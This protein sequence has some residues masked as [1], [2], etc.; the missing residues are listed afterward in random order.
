ML[1]VE[2]EKGVQ[3]LSVK[4]VV[5]A[6]LI[7]L[8]LAIWQTT[9]MSWYAPEGHGPNLVLVVVAY[10]GLFAPF[11]AGAVT[12]T[13]L[14]FIYDAA[15]GGILGLNAGVYLA[16]FLAAGLIRQKLDPTAPF[17]LVIFILAIAMGAGLLNFLALFI[18][19]WTIPLTPFTL[20][21]TL[22]VFWV[23]SA[24]TAV[25]GPFLFWFMTWVLPTSGNA[26]EVE[27]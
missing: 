17:Y 11:T 5:T 26:G 16:A 2:E 3:T 6:G 14:G 4:G 25:L 10:L 20:D 9:I 24:L 27:Q 7:G 13:L 8:G 21:G 23:S 15:G 1:T 12:V 18:L 19:D 22:A